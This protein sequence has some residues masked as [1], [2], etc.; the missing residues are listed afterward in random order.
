MLL[1]I[2]WDGYNIKKWKMTRFGEDVK[3]LEPSFITDKI[4][5]QSNSGKQ[6]VSQKINTEIPYIQQFQSQVHAQ[7]DQQLDKMWYAFIQCSIIQLYE[8]LIHPTTWK[9]LKNISER[10][11]S[12]QANRKINGC[13][14]LA[15]RGLG[16][17]RELLLMGTGLLSVV[18]RM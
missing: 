9:N 18:M 16:K 6:A 4:V 7:A 3:K 1:H 5:N 15:G 11:C 10:S 17:N 2:H 8:V 12:E 14:G 13:L